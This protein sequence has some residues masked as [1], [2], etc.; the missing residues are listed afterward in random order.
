MSRARF[1]AAERSSETVRCFRRGAAVGVGVRPVGADG[2]VADGARG[3]RHGRLRRRLARRGRV[4]ENA[5][6][7]SLGAK[8][9]QRQAATQGTGCFVKLPPGGAP[10]RNRT[11]GGRCIYGVL[12]AGVQVLQKRRGLCVQEKSTP[13]H[14]EVRRVLERQKRRAL[15]ASASP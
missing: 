14:S 15:S 6:R 1:V 2:D 11:T 5:T 8:V 3:W 4:S 7:G 10:V 12:G 13:T 9:T